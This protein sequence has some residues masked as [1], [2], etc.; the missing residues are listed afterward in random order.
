MNFIRRFPFA[1]IELKAPIN[2]E[3]HRAIHTN[4]KSYGV[5][6]IKMIVSNKAPLNAIYIGI[7]PTTTAIIKDHPFHIHIGGN[8]ENKFSIEIHR[9]GATNG[10]ATGRSAG[11]HIMNFELGTNFSK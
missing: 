2:F 11:N 6:V 10:I 8:R 3:W 7:I 9:F 4:A 1:W 5:A